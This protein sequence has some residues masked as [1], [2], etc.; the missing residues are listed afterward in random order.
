VSQFRQLR[1]PIGR[2][3]DTPY[4]VVDTET[5]GLD[6]QVDR[7]VE[8]AALRF[9][10]GRVTDRFETLVDPERDI[11]PES[12]EHHHLTD[13]D[14]EGSPPLAAL[15]EPLLDFVGTDLIVAHNAAFDRQFVAVINGR[16]WV[17]SMRAARHL[18]PAAHAHR[19][20]YLRYWLKL[21]APEIRK[22][23]AHRAGSDA[24]VTGH[25]FHRELQEY[26]VIHPEAGMDDFISYV[27][28]PIPISELRFGKLHRGKPLAQVPGTYLQWMLREVADL[29]PD[30]RASIDAELTRRATPNAA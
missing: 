23:S 9:E 20:Q 14:I 12:S 30:L 17:C 7:V 1:L 29:D 15:D 16:R 11:P 6:A 4:V 28:S 19:N 10:G 8:I 24:L 25:I 18:W 22:A 5:T 3:S 2:L 26:E 13:S 27:A 21:D